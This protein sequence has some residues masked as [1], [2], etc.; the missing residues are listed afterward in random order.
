LVVKNAHLIIPAPPH[1]ATPKLYLN[2][3]W[4][5][6]L[7]YPTEKAASQ[8]RSDATIIYDVMANITRRIGK[9]KNVAKQ[10]SMLA[11]LYKSGYLQ[12]RFLEPDLNNI[13]GLV[14]QDGEVNRTQ[15]FDR[16]QDYLHDGNGPLHCSFDHANGK[17]VTW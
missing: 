16:I 9:D 4:R 10:H 2:G 11:S 17:P 8:T 13:E 12:E 1:P 5:L 3:E 15:L 14:R 6:T 7:S